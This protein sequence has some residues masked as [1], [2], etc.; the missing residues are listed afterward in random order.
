[1]VW[2]SIFL[3]LPFKNVRA[4]HSTKILTLYG[5]IAL[6]PLY[7]IINSSIQ[8]RLFILY[9]LTFP[10]MQHITN[11]FISHIV[12][13]IIPSAHHTK[14][15]SINTQYII[16]RFTL[17]PLLATNQWTRAYN[18]EPHTK[19]LLGRLSISAPLDKPTILHLPV[20]YRTTIARNIL[21]ILEGWL[22]YYEL[23]SIV[24]NHICRIVVSTSLRRITFHLLHVTHVAGDMGEYKIFTVLN[25]DS[26]G[27]D[28]DLMFLNG[29]NNVPIVCSLIVS[30]DVD[31]N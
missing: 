15:I 18:N 14:C 30:V 4:P 26:S 31:R 25:L 22:I 24:T 19:V 23:I 3:Y 9:I 7:L 6:I 27:L 13:S 28:C 2:Y 17:Q 21:G 8:I 1:M 29:S 12:P 5:L 11:I 16:H 10:G 20:V